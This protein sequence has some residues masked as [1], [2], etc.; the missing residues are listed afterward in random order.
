MDL[1]LTDEE[2]ELVINN[3][4]NDA[5]KKGDGLKLLGHILSMSRVFSTGF[6]GNSRDIYN[7]GRADFGL[8]IREIIMQHAFDKYV[9][10]LKKGVTANDTTTG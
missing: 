1:L 4:A 9:E 3:V 10:L 8:E 7:K 2:L 6:N 5:P